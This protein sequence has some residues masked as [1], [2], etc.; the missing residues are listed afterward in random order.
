MDLHNGFTGNRVLF[1][2]H[3]NV[4]KNIIIIDDQWRYQALL[5]KAKEDESVVC[6]CWW[7]A[8]RPRVSCSAQQMQQ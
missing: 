7:Y 1:K 3:Y 2:W 5:D 6:F 8:Q 4:I